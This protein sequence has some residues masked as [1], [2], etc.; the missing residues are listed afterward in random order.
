[1]QR[2]TKVITLLLLFLMSCLSI[3]KNQF[4][5]GEMAK[6]LKIHTVFPKDLNVLRSTYIGQLT[7][8]CNSCSR[9]YN[10]LFWNLRAT[11]HKRTNL[12]MDTHIKTNKK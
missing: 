11:S 5:S 2:F 10:I 9:E 1:M 6:Q 7:S 3:P 12:H 8:V 4:R